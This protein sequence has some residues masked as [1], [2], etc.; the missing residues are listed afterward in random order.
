MD[1]TELLASASALELAAWSGSDPDW[2]CRAD[3]VG[4]YTR[5][6]APSLG[7]RSRGGRAIGMS[8]HERAACLP[9]VTYIDVS[10]QEL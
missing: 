2:W 4:L 6:T 3:R 9:V 10:S 8:D 1:S 7:H 5:P